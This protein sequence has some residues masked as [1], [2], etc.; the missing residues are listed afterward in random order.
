MPKASDTR[1]INIL[2]VGKLTSLFWGGLCA[3]IVNQLVSDEELLNHKNASQI[4]YDTFEELEEASKPQSHGASEPLEEPDEHREP[5]EW[6]T[7]SEEISNPHESM[8]FT[9]NLKSLENILILQSK[10]IY[11]ITYLYHKRSHAV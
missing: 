10:P 4:I 3:R 2:L 9:I 6:I 1:L 5:T 7:S 11:C 8:R